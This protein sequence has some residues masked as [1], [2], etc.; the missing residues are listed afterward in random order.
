MEKHK[1]RFELVQ[2]QL[3]RTSE[4]ERE[5]IMGAKTT[6]LYNESQPWCKR[7]CHSFF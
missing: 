6:L 4:L 5:I 2:E 3:T 7:D 1:G